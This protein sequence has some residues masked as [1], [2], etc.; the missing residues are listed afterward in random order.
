MTLGER[1]VK[2]RQRQRC[3]VC[4]KADYF[5]FQVPDHVWNLIVPEGINIVCLACFDDLAVEAGV[6][7]SKD[8]KG[9]VFAGE[10]AA[11]ELEVKKR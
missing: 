5:D 11:L 4:W 10:M 2:N 7:Y 3:K 1:A 8:L 6:D 9:L